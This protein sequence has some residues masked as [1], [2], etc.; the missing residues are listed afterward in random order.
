MIVDSLGVPLA[1]G[2]RVRLATP[3]QKKALAIRDGG[4]TFSGCDAPVRWC[5]AHHM[6]DWGHGGRSDIDKMALLCRWHHGIAHRN[7]WTTGIDPDQW[8]WFRN[9]HGQSLLGPTPRTNPPR[10]PP[11]PQRSRTP[12]PR[13]ARAVTQERRARGSSARTVSSASASAATLSS[14]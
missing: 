4:C 10:R 7:G 2:D 8:V 1:M 9:P 14:R 13:T 12:R 3:T 6:P 5:D 11:P